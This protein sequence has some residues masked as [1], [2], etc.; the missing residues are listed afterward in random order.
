MFGLSSRR[1]TTRVGPRPHHHSHRRGLG[2]L[3]HKSHNNRSHAE[4]RAAGY[5]AAINNPNVG[6][7]GRRH[8]KRELRMMGRKPNHEKLSTR[9]R[10]LFHLGGRRENRR[11]HTTTTTRARRY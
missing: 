6:S 3:F 4:N 2:G 10:R 5:Q 11:Y 1:R 9:F 7:A 8:A